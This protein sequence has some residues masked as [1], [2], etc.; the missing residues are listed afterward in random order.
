MNFVMRKKSLHELQQK[1]YSKKLI[2]HNDLLHY[3]LSSNR[4][5]LCQVLKEAHCSGRPNSIL[6]HRSYDIRVMGQPPLQHLEYFFFTFD[7]Y[8]GCHLAGIC[9]LVY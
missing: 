8:Q 9:F 7:F 3:F 2:E 5:F 1:T 4:S 6:I